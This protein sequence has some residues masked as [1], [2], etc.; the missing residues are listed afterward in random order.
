MLAV[1]INGL[2]L[3]KYWKP[4]HQSLDEAAALKSGPQLRDIAEP[5]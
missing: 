4:H 2:N 5:L 1:P 3:E